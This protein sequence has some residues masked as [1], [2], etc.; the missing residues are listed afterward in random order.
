MGNIGDGER[1]EAA[2]GGLLQRWHKM[3]GSYLEGRFAV[4]LVAS[5]AEV[6]DFLFSSGFQTVARGLSTRRADLSH[7]V[8]LTSNHPQN[9]YVICHL[10]LPQYSHVCT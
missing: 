2:V 8:Q 5:L 9:M 7:S 1:R 10:S 6:S 3:Q 4:S